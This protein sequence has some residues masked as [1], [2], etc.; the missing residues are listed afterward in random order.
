MGIVRGHNW[1]KAILG[2]S[3]VFAT[4]LVQGLTE[5]VTVQI[6]PVICF[7]VSCELRMAFTFL[8]G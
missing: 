1:G 8:N 6:Q 7:C 5:T 4:F 3:T 2:A